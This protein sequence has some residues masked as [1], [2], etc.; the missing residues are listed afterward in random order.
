MAICLAPAS[1]SVTAR[2]GPVIP[3]E[4]KRGCGYRARQRHRI[5][6]CRISSP[7]P[8]GVTTP[9]GIV[10]AMSILMA[11]AAH[12]Y[13]GWFRIP[14]DTSRP[15]AGRQVAT[16]CRSSIL[17]NAGCRVTFPVLQFDAWGIAHWGDAFPLGQTVLWTSC[18]KVELFTS[19]ERAAR[20][21][22]EARC[23]LPGGKINY[24]HGLA[25]FLRRK[26]L[27]R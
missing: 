21:L 12:V 13:R 11:Q 19:N 22:V 14:V 23:G 2:G 15:L 8:C 20:G 9:E 25:P 4:I 6:N 5:E 10:A 26:S 16:W 7:P 17:S 18:A 27:Q 1:S 3:P 24:Q